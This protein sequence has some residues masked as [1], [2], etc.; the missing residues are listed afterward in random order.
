[1][2]TG[3]NNLFYRGRWAYGVGLIAELVRMCV[4]SELFNQLT[5]FR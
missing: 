4:S 3:P 2:V 1:M 5:D